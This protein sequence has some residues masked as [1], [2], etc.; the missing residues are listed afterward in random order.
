MSTASPVTIL[1]GG[2][3]VDGTGGPRRRADV[4]VQGDRIIDVGQHLAGDRVLDCSDSVIAPGF[5]DMHTH[6]DAQ[7]FWGPACTSSCWHGVT[8][9]VVGNCGF[10][11][12]PKGWWQISRSGCTTSW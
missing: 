6:Y 5:I 1:R 8:T 4:A 9:V 2:Q 7:L 12:A 11:L 3:V 10:S